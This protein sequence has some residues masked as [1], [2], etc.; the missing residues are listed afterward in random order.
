[1]RRTLDILKRSNIFKDQSKLSFDFVPDELPGRE[2]EMD[3]MGILFRPVIYDRMG[4]NALIRGPVGSGKTAVVKRFCSLLKEAGLENN[5]RIEA[6]HVNCRTRKSESMV[7]LSILNY[8]DPR[9]PDRGFSIPEMIEI[10]KKH[11]KKRECHLVIILDEADVLLKKAGSDLI[12]S[13]TRLQEEDPDLLGSISLILISQKP[14]MELMDRA[15]LSTFKRTNI[16]D[17]GRYDRDTLQLI[18]D[19]RIE[20]AFH[21]NVVENGVSEMIASM[22]EEYGDARFSIELLEKAGMVAEEQGSDTVM[23]EH[24]RYA[25]ADVKSFIFEES[26]EQLNI[27]E[28]IMLLSASRLLKRS[29]YC[30]TGELEDEYKALCEQINKRP[31]G[32]TQFWQYMKELD[33]FGLINTKKSG[34]GTVGNTTLITIEDVPVS[35][36]IEYLEGIFLK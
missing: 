19:Q 10:L 3:R 21:P 8:F 13:F 24:A 6:V 34:K 23:P 9:F 20:L 31:L 32:H 35:E 11:L 28:Q 36:L 4:Q 26:I 18:T 5:R 15:S 16:L 12:Y 14:I 30:S 1:M 27:H 29:A 33:A 17:F 2:K 25:K 22:S 7:M